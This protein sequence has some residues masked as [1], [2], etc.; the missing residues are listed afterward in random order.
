MADLNNQYDVA[1]IDE[2]QLIEESDRG[3]AWTNALLGLQA[4]EIHL[5]GDERALRLISRLL[6]STGDE[7]FISEYKRLSTLNVEHKTIGGFSDFK[8]GDCI[9]AF[10]RKTVF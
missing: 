2:I 8:P 5:C 9:V 7:L 4:R 6:E 1:V 3:Y 10:S